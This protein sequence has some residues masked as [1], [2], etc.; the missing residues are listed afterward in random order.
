MFITFVCVPRM[1]NFRNLYSARHRALKCFEPVDRPESK[2]QG[3]RLTYPL[4]VFFS[5]T[6]LQKKQTHIQLRYI[7]IDADGY[8]DV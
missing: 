8:T 6:S 3:R 1:L 2:V 5:F 7:L 4:T